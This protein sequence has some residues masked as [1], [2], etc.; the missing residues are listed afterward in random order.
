MFKNIGTLDRTLRLAAGASL[1]ALWFF[2]P[3][4]LVYLIGFVPLVTGLVS[5]CPVYR[6]LGLRTN[7]PTTDARPGTK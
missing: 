7:R 3:S 2:D 1:L 5:F 6:L 4:N